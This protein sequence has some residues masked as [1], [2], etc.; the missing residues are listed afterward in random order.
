MIDTLDAVLA[1]EAMAPGEGRGIRYMGVRMPARAY[2]HLQ[3]IAEREADGN[4]SDLVRAALRDWL[5]L[6]HKRR[7]TELK[8]LAGLAPDL[9]EQ[10]RGLFRALPADEIDDDEPLKMTANDAGELVLRRADEPTY[11]YHLFDGHAVRLR[12]LDD[13][14]GE[15]TLW[16]DGV[17]VERRPFS[18]A[19]FPLSAWVAGGNLGGGNR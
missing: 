16:R 18:R 3:R 7:Q 8:R 10:A 4:L 14:T 13:E 12:A 2:E 19:S 6:Y 11:Q 1:L 17:E 9:A 5:K 15:L